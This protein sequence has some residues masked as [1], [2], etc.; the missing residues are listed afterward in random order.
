MTHAAAAASLVFTGACIAC[1]VYLHL[2]RIEG[3]SPIEKTVSE[4]GITPKGAWYRA[5]VRF[6]A[7]A[8][9]LLA[10]AL[11]HPHHVIVLLLVFAVARAA[12]SFFPIIS[13]AHLLL[14]VAAFVSAASAATALKRPEHGLPA[15]GYAMAACLVLL[16]AGRAVGLRQW[17]GL[18]ERGFYIS[19]LSWLCL[20][21]VRLL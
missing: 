20:V 15:L 17:R 9:A 19:M 16:F 8:A 13:A 2:T 11:R 21:A 1:L 7:A 10:L 14:A 5:Q 6:A 3:Y 18:I 12:I 4:Y